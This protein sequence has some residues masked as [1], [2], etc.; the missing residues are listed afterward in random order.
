MQNLQQDLSS[1]EQLEL[2]TLF[3]KHREDSFSMV[4]LDG[5][6]YGI[7][8]LPNMP[9]PT[10]WI[11][12]VLPESVAQSQKKLSRAIELTFR[13]YNKV[14]SAMS[15][16][17][18]K[19]RFDGTP[20]QATAWLEGFGRAFRYDM[21]AV[22]ELADVEMDILGKSR[23]DRLIYAPIVLSLSVDVA[24]APSDKDRDEIIQLKASVLKMYSEQSVEKNQD[25]LSHL[26]STVH[27]L[28]K[29]A[30][31]QQMQAIETKTRH[32][33]GQ[34]ISRNSPCFCGSG[35]KYKHCHGKLG[36]KE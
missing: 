6:F 34:K 30:R 4:S 21:N 14:L 13:Y 18:P 1:A 35:K 33:Q 26:I 31:E 7:A 11:Q 2:F 32:E 24:D 3:P 20:A 28:L 8:C 17:E 27:L 16:A 23:D 15:E 5:F 19:P 12:E 9:N 25:L 10:Q 36:F 22:Q 29:P